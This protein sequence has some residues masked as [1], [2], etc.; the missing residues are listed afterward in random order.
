[1]ELS[2]AYGCLFKQV[3]NKAG[4]F[5]RTNVVTHPF[6]LVQSGALGNVKQ[7]PGE[8]EFAYSSFTPDS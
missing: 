6:R 7:I 3:T 1:M 5:K 8:E 2:H 4:Q